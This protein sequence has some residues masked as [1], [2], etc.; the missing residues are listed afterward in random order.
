LNISRRNFLS[1]AAAFPVAA[2]AGYQLG[3][4][5]EVFLEDLS[6]RAFLFFWEQADPHTGLVR[7]RART[8]GT[9]TT[10]HSQEVASMASTGFGLTALCIAAAR[11]WEKPA[12]VTERVRNTLR[13]LAYNQPH[14][15]GWYYHFVDM[16]SGQRVWGCE[17]S[18]IDTALLLAGVLTAQQFFENDAEMVRLADEIYERVDFGWML[19]EATGLLRMGWLPEQG[20]LRSAWVNYRENPILH[21]LAIASPTHPI[22]VQSWYLFERDPVSFEGRHWVGGGAIFTHQFPQAWLD[23]RG[24]RDGLP[25]RMNYFDNSIIATKAHRDYCLSLRSIFPSFSE[26][27]WGVSPSDSDIGYLTWGT[28]E[29]RQDFDGSIVPCVAAGSLMFTPELSLAALQTMLNQFGP[30]AYGRYGFADAF[31]PM[32]GWVNPDIV[33]IDQGIS[34]ISAENL[35]TGRVWEWFGRSENIQRAMRR[36]FTPEGH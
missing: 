23:L 36:I 29:S 9:K 4:T 15:L 24:L 14:E 28:F 1:L 21:M 20:F 2:V 16:R 7:D 8:A 33:G 5:D 12:L 19:D 35:R 3:P 30:Y 34:L 31:N 10:G 6:R 27:L 18:T 32:S 17:L 25:F 11:G 22:P 26:N 13:H